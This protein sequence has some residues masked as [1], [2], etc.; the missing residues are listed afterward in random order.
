[1]R[2][3]PRFVAGVTALRHDGPPAAQAVAALTAHSARPAAD[4]GKSGA[5]VRSFAKRPSGSR[6]SPSPKAE[7]YA[8]QFGCVS[9]PDSGAMGLHYVNF[10]LVLD[11]ELDADAARDR[12]LRAVGNGRLR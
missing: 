11:G 1:M 10:P 6:T 2:S 3:S 5:L 7:G 9:G 4:A 12:H 8:L